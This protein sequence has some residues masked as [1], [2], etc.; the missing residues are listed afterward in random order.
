M[1]LQTRALAKIIRKLKKYFE[2]KK[3]LKNLGKISLDF[4]Q[5]E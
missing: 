1:K 2:E 4:C 3:N 5:C